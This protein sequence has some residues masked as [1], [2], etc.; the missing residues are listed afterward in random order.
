MKKTLILLLAIFFASTVFG[1]NQRQQVA[2]WVAGPD[3]ARMVVANELVRVVS[4]SDRYIAVERSADFLRLMTDEIAHQQGGHVD[5]QIAELGR[6][7]GVQLVL[8]ATVT[9]FGETNHIAARIINAQTGLISRAATAHCRFATIDQVINT[10]DGLASELLGIPTRADRE[11]VQD[12]IRRV[13]EQ[14]ENIRRDRERGFTASGNFFIQTAFSA[15]GVQYR[16]AVNACRDS[17]TGGFNDWRLPTA[18]EAQRII[19]INNENGGVIQLGQEWDRSWI[20]TTTEI[21]NHRHATFNREG[22]TGGCGTTA[23]GWSEGII[24]NRI[25][26]R[27]PSRNNAVCVRGR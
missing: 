23:G 15:V 12:S 16:E 22:R 25:S 3:P 21:G 18:A 19:V 13:A 1:Q 10:S 2:V 24:N 5:R 17:R 6:Q 9:P 4:A 8:V 7:L 27:S 20:W 11:R 26:N 14:A